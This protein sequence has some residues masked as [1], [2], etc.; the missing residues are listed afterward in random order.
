MTKLWTLQDGICRPVQLHSLRMPLL[1]LQGLCTDRA[2]D[3][4]YAM[5]L[6]SSQVEHV[7]ALALSAGL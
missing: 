7:G 6:D 3:A 5:V 2:G 4:C 1:F